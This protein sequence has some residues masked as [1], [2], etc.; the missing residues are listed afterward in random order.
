MAQPG[1][2][3]PFGPIILVTTLAVSLAMFG[4]SEEVTPAPAEVVLLSPLGKQHTTSTT[5]AVTVAPGA[6]EPPESEQNAASLQVSET[7]LN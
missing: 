1:K 2:E 4:S 6:S 7:G 5:V 3:N